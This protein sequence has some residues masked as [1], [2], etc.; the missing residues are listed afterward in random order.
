[1]SRLVSDPDRRPI[2]SKTVMYVRIISDNDPKGR[3]GDAL[4]EAAGLALTA[5]RAQENGHQRASQA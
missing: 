1:V 3:V 5:T 2:K 4:Q